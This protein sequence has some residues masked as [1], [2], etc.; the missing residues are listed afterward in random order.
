MP[1]LR[2]SLSCLLVLFSLCRFAPSANAAGTLTI[3]GT[4]LDPTGAP[5]PEASVRL[6]AASAPVNR[7]QTRP[8]GSF[9]F[10]QLL[11]GT[12]VLECY[13]EGF[14]KLGRR[15][16]LDQDSDALRL[17]LEIAG[18]NQHV[19]VIASELPELPSE[20]SKA[21]S[22]VSTEELG[23][24]DA[25]ILTDA[26]RQIPSLQIQQ[27]GGPGALAGYRFRGLRPEDTSILLDGFRFRDPSDNKNSARPFLSDLLVPRAERI[28]VL[29]GAGS[30]L[31]GTNAIGGTVNVVSQQP[32]Q[33]LGGFFSF[34]GGS[35][36]LWQG[37][38]GLAGKI[39]H[40]RLDYSVQ[41][42]HLN[43]TEGLDG[44][45]TYRINSGSAWA[46]Y[47]LTPGSRLFFKY[48]T[49]DSF[50]L[51]NHS[52]SPLPDLTPLPAGQSVRE[53]IP[54]PASQATFHP[55]FD[56]PDNHRHFRYLGGAIRLDHQVNRFW[57]HSL[58][59]QSLRTRR[60]FDNG[61]AV[62]PESEAFG[63]QD[64]SAKDRFDGAL[65]EIS[66]LHRFS[67][68]RVNTTQLLLEFER[69]HLDQFVFG[70]ATEATQSS[71]AFSAANQ[72]RLLND[73]LHLQ[74][75]F[76]SQGYRL[77]SPR[78]SDETGNPFTSAG[79][80]KV[81]ATYNGDLSLAYFLAGWNTKFRVHAGNGYRSPSLFER[82]GGGGTGS[83]RSYFG[84]PL[85][86]AERSTFMDG[87]L[88]HFAWNNKLQLS[89]TYFYTHLQTIIDFGPTPAD[90]FNRSFGYI[91]LKGGN[92]RGVELSVSSRP[93]S[94]LDFAGSYTLT[95]SN[96]P[97]PTSA[98]TTRVL[99][100]SEHQFTFQFHARPTRRFQLSFQ[101][102]A[103]SAHDFP[104]FGLVF[105]IPSEIFRF[106]GYTL[107]DLTGSYVLHE[108]ERTRLRFVARIDNLLNQEYYQGGFQAPKATVRTGFY[109]DF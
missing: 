78:F 28:E 87:G 85:L 17:T 81:P 38:A 95:K 101:G 48:H 13:K 7:T 60:R 6:Y 97:S 55:Q 69:S 37:T 22:L 31:Y 58:G 75:A 8:D 107:M 63:F 80:L 68:H 33:P 96:Q 53:A 41:A 44:N 91:N 35:L 1:T 25:L 11:E 70:L 77:N 67:L 88:D 62:S 32:T 99:G 105:T 109:F 23:N 20:V 54:F 94:F 2:T 92:A 90:R 16:A 43:Y 84:N 50:L 10:S 30:A 29:R 26:L 51:L 14:Q 5:V 45:D 19:V 89:A 108:G 24:R 93:T 64:F 39:T 102:Y 56:D 4:V 103:V 100:L 47:K 49:A 36:G 42:A 66:W 21:V 34:Q 3:S 15:V 73:R 40:E 61:P 59:Y 86:R 104:L 106:D 12:Y 71:L 83:F 9:E 72:T 76:R 27:L 57:S 98:G 18:L 74:F 82:F 79:D 46:A 65:D 52:P